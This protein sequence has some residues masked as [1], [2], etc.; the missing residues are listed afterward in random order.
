M[1]RPESATEKVRN[2][3][4]R[5]RIKEKGVVENSRMKI[6]SFHFS[7]LLISLRPFQ[8]T[9]PLKRSR[10][11]KSGL[12]LALWSSLSE[13]AEANGCKFHSE[14][15]TCFEMRILV[16]RATSLMLYRSGWLGVSQIIRRRQCLVGLTCATVKKQ[17]Q[18][19]MKRDNRLWTLF[20]AGWL[21]GWLVSFTRMQKADKW[22]TKLRW[23]FFLGLLLLILSSTC[24]KSYLAFE[25]STRWQ[26]V[27]VAAAR[28][29]FVLQNRIPGPHSIKEANFN[30]HLRSA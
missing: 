27:T 15:W 4:A 11:A 2:S 29:Y 21:A 14:L 5:R 1:K 17:A 18:E 30:E 13:K 23:N 26:H 6:A 19:K 3:S 16:R 22:L 9:W 25:Y 12:R 8:L 24:L 28:R 20:T 7:P 10:P